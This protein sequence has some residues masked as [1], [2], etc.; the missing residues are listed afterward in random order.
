M[1][2]HNQGNLTVPT[3]LFPDGSVMTNPPIGAVRA[4]MHG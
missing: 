3:V 2:E 4:R 1:A